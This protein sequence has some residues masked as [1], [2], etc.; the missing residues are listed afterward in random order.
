MHEN[1]K[2]VDN[3]WFKKIIFCFLDLSQLF[4]IINVQEDLRNNKSIESGQ[5]AQTH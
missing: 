4:K 2:L 5:Q 1:A 3:I